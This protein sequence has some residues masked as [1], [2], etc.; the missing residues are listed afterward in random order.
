MPR[1]AIT[2]VRRVMANSSVVTCGFIR[3]TYAPATRRKPIG[4]CSRSP[5]RD[6]SSAGIDGVGI[7][8]LIRVLSSASTFSMLLATGVIT[9]RLSRGDAGLQVGDELIDLVWLEHVTV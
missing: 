5:G 8:E 1:C 9:D 3:L 2:I 6:G 4:R 7:A